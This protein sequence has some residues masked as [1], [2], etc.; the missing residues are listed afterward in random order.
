M[1]DFI[2]AGFD[3]ID[4]IKSDDDMKKFNRMKE[5]EKELHKPVKECLD[6]VIEYTK[7]DRELRGIGPIKIIVQNNPKLN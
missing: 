2:S 5:L 1:S 4:F 7:L 3:Y 6:A